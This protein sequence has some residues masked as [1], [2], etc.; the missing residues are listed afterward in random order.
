MYTTIELWFHTSEG[1]P[2][3]PLWPELPSWLFK[4]LLPCNCA[5]HNRTLVWFYSDCYFTLTV[6]LV[7]Y[8][9]DSAVLVMHTYSIRGNFKNLL[10]VECICLLHYVTW[11]QYQHTL[12]CL[13]VQSVCNC[14]VICLI[15]ELADV[16]SLCTAVL[17]SE[18]VHVLFVKFYA[19]LALYIF[20]SGWQIWDVLHLL[21]CRSVYI[22]MYFDGVLLVYASVL[23]FATDFSHFC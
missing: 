18:V 12:L 4:P 6:S 15:D 9:W 23:H 22:C 8:V 3:L 17:V 16:A 19:S 7:V 20:R 10:T 2:V 13:L 5:L 21:Y 11:Q 1:I 14:V